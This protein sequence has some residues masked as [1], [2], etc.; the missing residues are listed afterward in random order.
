MNAGEVDANYQPM[1]RKDVPWHE[2]TRDGFFRG[3]SCGV[4]LV[5]TS[6]PLV[7][8]LASPGARTP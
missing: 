2:T 4:S 1:D 3:P 5:Q 7:P 6:T 8:V